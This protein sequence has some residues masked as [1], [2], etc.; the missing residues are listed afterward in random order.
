[1]PSNFHSSHHRHSLEHEQ[2]FKIVDVVDTTVVAV[3]HKVF[4]LETSRWE[5]KYASLRRH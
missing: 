1:M 5:K 4:I 3:N 2:I